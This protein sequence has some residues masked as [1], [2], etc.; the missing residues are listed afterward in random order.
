MYTLQVRCCL[1]HWGRVTHICISK[2]MI[3]GSDN[4]LLPDQCQAIIWTN[5]GILLIRTL[6]TNFSEI[7]GKIHSFSFKKMHFRMSTAKG[8]LF[9]LG[10]TELRNHENICSLLFLYVHMAHVVK[11]SPESRHESTV[12]DHHN[13]VNF[14][15]NLQNNHPITHIWRWD[16]G[17]LLWVQSLACFT[18]QK[19]SNVEK[20][21][22]GFHFMRVSWTHLLNILGH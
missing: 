6:G 7:L 17:C 8:R 1:T 11:I 19:N 9:S 13:R 12:T 22:M 18:A 4:G 5:A 3:I 14:H 21:S 2:L 15:Q 10:F 20:A 16:M